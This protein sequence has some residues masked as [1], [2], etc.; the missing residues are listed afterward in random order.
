MTIDF[1]TPNVVNEEIEVE[2]EDEEIDSEIKFWESALIMYVIGREISM[3]VVKQFMEK[4]WNFV[5][6]PYLYY[7]EEGYFIM[8]FHS[9]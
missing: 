3:N 1:V 6:L 5:K 4:N 7:N 2:I 8:R 9:L